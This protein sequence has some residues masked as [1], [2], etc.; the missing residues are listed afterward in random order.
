[1]TREEFEAVVEKALE[2]L[3]NDI[4]GHLKNIEIVIEELPKGSKAKKS[5]LLGLYE[6][7]PLN[8]RSD[9]F[10][11][12][13]LPDKITLF[14]KNIEAFCS[15]EDEMVEEIKK[16][17]LHEIGHYFGMDDKQLRRMGY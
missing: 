3:P 6:G 8:E 13:V 9:S 12:G 7:I 15:N 5:L 4:A 16:T 2:A 14:Q 17:L 1:M 11:A 10:Y